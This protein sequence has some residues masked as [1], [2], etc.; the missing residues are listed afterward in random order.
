[1]Y[2]LLYTFSDSSDTDDTAWFTGDK[3][4]NTATDFPET[5]TA[6][7]GATDVVFHIQFTNPVTNATPSL[8][9]FYTAAR[10]TISN[11]GVA[12][13]ALSGAL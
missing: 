8:D 4:V 10:Y 7:A 6:A 5:D 3:D 11:G 2:S 1:M 9:A 13:T 12:D